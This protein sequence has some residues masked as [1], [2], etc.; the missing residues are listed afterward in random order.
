MADEHSLSPEELARQARQHVRSL[1]ASGLEWLPLASLQMRHSAPA[2]S[3]GAAASAAPDAVT[4]SPE[5]ATP[6]GLFVPDAD[7]V[8]M[9]I[10]E[11]RQALE[12]VREQVAVCTRCAELCSSRTQTVFGEGPFDPELCFVGEAPGFNEDRL[13]RPFVGEAGQLLDKIIA[14]CGFT[15]QEVYICNILRC[16]PPGNRLP[17]VNE[18]ENCREYLEKTLEL[19]RPRYICALGAC[20]AQNLL[21]TTSSIGKLRRRFHDYRGTTVLCTYHPAYLLRNPT[22]K[23]DVWEDMKLL[24]GRI[25]RPVPKK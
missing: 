13:G 5:L 21:G 15:R 14:A 18:A 4:S 11:R 1:Q 22:S 10:E 8:E 3:P 12:L 16:R 9:P 23:R 2:E 6:G 19:I 20:A 25:G 17:L 24:L 7:R